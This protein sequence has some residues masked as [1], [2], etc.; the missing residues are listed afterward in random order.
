MKRVEIL[1]LTTCNCVIQGHQTEEILYIL[2]FKDLQ[3]LGPF[4]IIVLSYHAN[5]ALVDAV[6]ASSKDVTAA[7]VKTHQ[8]QHISRFSGYVIKKL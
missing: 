7:T 8:N 1:H 3:N 5:K 4:A 2:I 6:A